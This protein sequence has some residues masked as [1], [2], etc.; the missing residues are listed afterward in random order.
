M[1]HHV[2]AD[3]VTLP[4]GTLDEW[5]QNIA[6]LAVGN[7]RLGLFIAAAFAAPL[8]DVTSERTGGLH[9]HG[10]SQSSKTTLL[11]SAASPVGPWRY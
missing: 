9:V 6:R 3:D 2:A 11:Q 4:R 8:L 7:H 5:Q 1:L 10:N